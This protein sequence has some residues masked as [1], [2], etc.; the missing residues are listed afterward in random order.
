MSQIK[1]ITEKINKSIY[2]KVKLE[3]NLPNYPSEYYYD[4]I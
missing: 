2:K 3:F 4:L 1:F